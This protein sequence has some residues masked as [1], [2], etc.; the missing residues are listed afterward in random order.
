MLSRRRG[1]SPLQRSA[2]LGL[3]VILAPAGRRLGQACDLALSPAG[4]AV[5]GVVVEGGWPRSRRILDRRAVAGWGPDA[6]VAAAEQWLAPEAGLPAA[7]L[8]GKPV[9]AP[10]GRELGQLDDLEFDPA[11]GTLT[12][13]GLSAGL[14][15]DL[16]HGK[17]RLASGLRLGEAV[18]WAEPAAEP[19]VTGHE[20]RGAEIELS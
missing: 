16:L 9:L 20:A 15:A 10:P 17:S 7:A 14:V 12:A 5:L 2:I 11:S 3:P 4:G 8:A 1:R 18:L 6:L 19:A 13:V